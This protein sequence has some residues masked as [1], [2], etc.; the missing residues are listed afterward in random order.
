M[1][2]V[3]KMYMHIRVDQALHTCIHIYIYA[4]ENMCT[5]MYICIYI[6]LCV[7]MFYK[8]VQIHYIGVVGLPDPTNV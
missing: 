7:C 8:Y 6:Y 1:Y 3:Y 5:Y 2:S 4:F